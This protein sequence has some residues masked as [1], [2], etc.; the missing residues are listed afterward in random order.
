MILHVLLTII[1]VYGEGNKRL[2][3]ED[4]HTHT[5]TNTIAENNEETHQ[6]IGY[7]LEAW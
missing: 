7:N 2:I 1:C 4:T 3:R 5:I 6:D